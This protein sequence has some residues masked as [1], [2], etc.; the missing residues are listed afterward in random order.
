MERPNFYL[1]IGVFFFERKIPDVDYDENDRPKD[2]IRSIVEHAMFSGF[3]D[4]GKTTG[5]LNDCYG[6]SDIV[7]EGL[8]KELENTMDWKY[9]QQIRFVKNYQ[10]KPPCPIWCLLESRI[11]EANPELQHW[12][13]TWENSGKDKGTMRMMS[14]QIDEANFS[15]W[16]KVR[17]ELLAVGMAEEKIPIALYVPTEDANL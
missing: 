3:L 17:E 16:R 6:K 9:S 1:L 10:N 8:T 11:S 5:E 2:I 12:V 4:T 14:I 7:L 13:G 15:N